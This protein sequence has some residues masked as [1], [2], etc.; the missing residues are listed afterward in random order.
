MKLI[1]I[2]G[3]YTGTT[4]EERNLNIEHARA[5]GREVARLGHFPVI[6]HCNSAYFDDTAPDIPPEF[7]L[8]GDIVLMKRCDSVL[9]MLGWRRSQGA[10]NEFEE[11][12]KAGLKIHET[13]TEIV[14]YNK[15]LDSDLA[16]II[17]NESG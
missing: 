8:E 3:C 5:V 14:E 7:W 13:F 4:K 12:K 17:G 6:P 9:F 16:G 1:Y 15:V 11:A 2:A 10:L